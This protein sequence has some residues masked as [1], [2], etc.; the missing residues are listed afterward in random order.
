MT[1]NLIQQPKTKPVLF[2]L[3][4]LLSGIVIGVG[5]TLMV[6]KPQTQDPSQKGPEWM[7][8]RMVSHIIR[9]LNLP[10]EKKAELLP[11]IQEHMQAIDAIR[12]EARPKITEIINDMNAGIMET[13][14]DDQKLAWADQMDQMKK[15]F[16][17]MRKGGPDGDRRRRG[18]GNGQQDG[19]RRR[20]GDGD[21]QGGPDG[22]RRDKQRRYDGPGGD[23]N[24]PRRPRQRPWNEIMPPDEELLKTLP[25]Q[26]GPQ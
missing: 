10:E 5:L 17:R 22:E 12:Q 18:D 3:L 13:L 25:P 16:D 8:E 20:R 21:G 7:S 6:I 2:S 26:D 9:D 1:E 4:T 24:S 11:I 19:E 23:P 15:R 14:D